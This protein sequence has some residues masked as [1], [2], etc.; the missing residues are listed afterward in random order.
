MSDGA[1]GRRAATHDPLLATLRGAPRFEVLM[2][3]ARANERDI[4]A[5]A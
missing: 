4:E 2:Q 3:R 5:E 1:T